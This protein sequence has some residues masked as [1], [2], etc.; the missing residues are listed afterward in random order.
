MRRLL[1]VPCLLAMLLW[2]AG[3]APEPQV[4][5]NIQ[6]KH[7]SHEQDT[8]KAW[9]ARAVEPPEKDDQLLGLLLASKPKLSAT[10]EKPPGAEARLETEDILSH[11]RKALWGPEPDRD[12]LYHPPPEED[13]DEERPWLWAMPPRRV[14][15]G[16]EE[17]RDHIYHPE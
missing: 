11:V 3:T 4:P 9:G 14:L 10:E 7:G 8:E 16:P 5:V 6:V 1:L 13:Q 2:E 15:R 12:D 17:D